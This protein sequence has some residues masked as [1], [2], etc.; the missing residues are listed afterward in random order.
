MRESIRHQN[1][2]ILKT[3]RYV[4][5]HNVP[6]LHKKRTCASKLYKH[7]QTERLSLLNS[8]IICC[9][10]S[11]SLSPKAKNKQDADKRNPV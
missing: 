3:H 5:A 10:L 8:Q 11:L 7:K 9:V 1:R 2:S 6:T 4:Q